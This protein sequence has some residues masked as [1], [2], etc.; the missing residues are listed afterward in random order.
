MLL[1]VFLCLT[2]LSSTMAAT[3]TAP[4]FLL[5]ADYSELAFFLGPIAT[6]ASGALYGFSYCQVNTPPAYP[7]SPRA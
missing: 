4:G 6:D 7:S 5:G 2:L 3:A 1:R